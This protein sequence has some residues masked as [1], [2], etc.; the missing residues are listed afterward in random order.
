MNRVRIDKAACVSGG[1]C[2][3][4]APEAFGFDDDELG[5]VLP[6]ANDLPLERLRRIAADCP[7]QAIE[8]AAG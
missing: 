4:A 7:G 3:L 1:R 6:G 8:V 5:E 2:V